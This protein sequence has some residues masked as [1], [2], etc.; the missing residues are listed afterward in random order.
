[1]V[2][3]FNGDGKP[4]LAVG[5]FVGIANIASSSNSV[6]V[7]LNQGNGTFGPQSTYATGKY[8]SSIAVGDFNGDGKPDLAVVNQGDNTVGVLLNMGNG[9]FRSQ[10]AYA[11]GNVPVSV[12]VGDF[13]GD[14]KPDLAVT[15]GTDN[16]VSVLV[17]EGNGIFGRKAL[18]PRALLLIPWWWATSTATA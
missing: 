5:N 3:D 6:S 7:L 8:T 11:A 13:N 16:T 17:N 2:G 1:M 9:T 18:M 14:G 15:N 10:T 12:A 4:D